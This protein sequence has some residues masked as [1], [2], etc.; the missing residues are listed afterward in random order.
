M[1]VGCW[2]NSNIINAYFFYTDGYRM[3]SSQQ[4]TITMRGFVVSLWCSTCALR[5]LGKENYFDIPEVCYV[6]A[7][8][9][10]RLN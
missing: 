4:L 3:A 1:G 2:I 9:I 7:E 8:T 5:D 10:D 6:D